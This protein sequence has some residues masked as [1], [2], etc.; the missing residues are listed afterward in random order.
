MSPV[1]DVSVKKDSFPVFALKCFEIL[2]DQS[3]S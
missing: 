3:G 1:I 2:A